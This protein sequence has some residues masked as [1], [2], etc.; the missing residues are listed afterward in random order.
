MKVLFVC[1]GN[2]CRSP[3]AE[4]ILR[5]IADKRNIKMEI[6]SAGTAVYDGEKASKNTIEAM[7]KIGIDISDHRATQLHRDLVDGA[8]LILTLSGSHKEHILLKYPSSKDKLFTLIEYAYGIEK[9]IADPFGRN[10]GVYE[11]TRDEICQAITN[12]K[13]VNRE[14]D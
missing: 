10:Q 9:D 5:D 12:I 3:M 13:I 1:T 6:Q 8:D 11:K 14:G 7:G 2:T 4:G